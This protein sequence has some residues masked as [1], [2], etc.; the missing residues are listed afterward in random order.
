MQAPDPFDADEPRTEAPAWLVE[1]A[2]LLGV[3]VIGL[4]A[5]LINE[6]RA[7]PEGPAA[8]AAISVTAATEIINTEFGA[9]QSYLPEVY[10]PLHTADALFIDRTTGQTLTVTEELE[11]AIAREAVAFAHYPV[12]TTEVEVAGNVAVYGTTWGLNTD[13]ERRGAGIVIVTFEGGRISREVVMSMEGV[14][15]TDDLLP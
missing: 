2:F 14:R 5:W 9:L 7:E 3:A 4:G 1:I 12:R 10:G 6:L 13:S 15:A 8:P 11:D